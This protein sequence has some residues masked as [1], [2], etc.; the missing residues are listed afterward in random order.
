MKA[1]E[2]VCAEAPRRVSGGR[3]A[4][5]GASGAVSVEAERLGGLSYHGTGLDGAL[6]VDESRVWG[7]GVGGG[8]ETIEEIGRRTMGTVLYT[9]MVH[10]VY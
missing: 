10:V 2:L 6:C 3:R 7:L 1:I 8:R 9:S 4:A 5:W